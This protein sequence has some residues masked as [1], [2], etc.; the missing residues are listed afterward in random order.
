MKSWLEQNGI[1]LYY[2]RNEV[3]SFFAERITKT[4]KNNLQDFNIKKC[5]I[6]KL[7]NIVNKFNNT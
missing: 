7:D 2:T 5:V 1:E 4:L 6:D 3:K